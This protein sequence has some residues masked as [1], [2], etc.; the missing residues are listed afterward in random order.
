MPL[1]QGKLL[2]LRCIPI[3]PENTGRS[4]LRGRHGAAFSF[5]FAVV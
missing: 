3:S 4:G 5:S 1:P 2:T